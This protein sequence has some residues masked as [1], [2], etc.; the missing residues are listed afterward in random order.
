MVGFYFNS[1]KVGDFL[2]NCLQYESCSIYFLIS[3][4]KSQNWLNGLVDELEQHHKIRKNHW[5]VM[6]KVF[7]SV[8]QHKGLDNIT[9]FMDHDLAIIIMQN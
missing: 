4:F 6:M 5:M 7:E 9:N 3:Y 1:N 2:K 8:G